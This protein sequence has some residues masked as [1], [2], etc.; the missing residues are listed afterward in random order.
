MPAGAVYSARFRGS[1]G[2]VKHV[3][4][5]RRAGG[6]FAR[7]GTFR[8]IAGC[9]TIRDAT[10]ARPV[11]GARDGKPLDIR[12]RL[13]TRARVEVTVAR[14]K[15]RVRRFKTR[16]R[17]PGRTIRLRMPARG[18][19]RGTYHVTIRARPVGAPAQTLHLTALR[20]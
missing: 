14:G 8:T 16:N 9:G 17:V 12:F 2:A 19:A 6:R 4:L 3:T 1:G 7:R 13:N 15:Q 11:F 10:L 5:A 20:R 18:H